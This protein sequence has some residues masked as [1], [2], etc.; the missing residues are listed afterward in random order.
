MATTGETVFAG[1]SRFD[2]HDRI[3]AFVAP[4][5]SIASAELWDISGSAKALL[6][7]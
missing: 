6:H 2:A 4:V 7:N 3:A 1:G 5:V